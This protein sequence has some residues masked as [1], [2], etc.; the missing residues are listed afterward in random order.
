[1]NHGEII[2]N[3]FIYAAAINKIAGEDKQNLLLQELATDAQG[4]FL[5]NPQY[6][7]YTKTMFQDNVLFANKMG[8]V[9]PTVSKGWKYIQPRVVEVSKPF[10]RTRIPQNEIVP[11]T[12]SLME[13]MCYRKRNHPA[14][15]AIWDTQKV[16]LDDAMCCVFEEELQAQMDAHNNSVSLVNSTEEVVLETPNE[17]EV[18]VVTKSKKAK[19]VV[20]V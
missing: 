1:M 13:E 9:L 2:R 12:V 7:G 4:V 14:F 11:F 8:E 3:F 6:V 20:E 10:N 18:K 17:E 19:Q 16:K 5:A 15:K